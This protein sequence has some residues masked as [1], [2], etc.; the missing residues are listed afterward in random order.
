MGRVGRNGE[1]Q[2]GTP[3]A[4]LGTLRTYRPGHD[5]VIKGQV[6]EGDAVV[7]AVSPHGGALRGHQRGGIVFRRDAQRSNT[8]FGVKL[9]HKVHSFHKGV[10]GEQTFGTVLVIEGGSVAPY[11]VGGPPDAFLG[12]EAVHLVGALAGGQLLGVVQEHIPGPFT[13]LPQVVGI[14]QP[15]IFYHFHIVADAHYVNFGRHAGGISHGAV[16]LGQMGV[17]VPPAGL[18]DIV[19]GLNVGG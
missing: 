2:A 16:G 1:G 13:T 5:A 10:I 18:I 19:G 11:P 8:I 12:G 4:S 17:E 9:E 7:Q 6:L 15:G 14:F 3:V